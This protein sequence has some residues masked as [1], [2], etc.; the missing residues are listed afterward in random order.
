LIDVSDLHDA[1]LEEVVVDAAGGCVR[2]ELGPVRREGAPERVFIRAV[3]FEHFVFPRQQPWGLVKDWHVNE[4][5][6]SALTG[7]LQRLEL[8]MQSG[9]VVEISAAN[10]ERSDGRAAPY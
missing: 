9:D 8:E 7:E 2:L 3:Q 6:V 5:R 4:A 10:F 1:V